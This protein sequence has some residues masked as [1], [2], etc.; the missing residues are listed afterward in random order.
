MIPRYDP[1]LGNLGLATWPKERLVALI[2]DEEGEFWTTPLKS[3]GE[4]L[5]L[6]FEAPRNG[7][8]Q[9]EIQGGDG[10]TI[11]RCDL[12]TGDRLKKEV[13]W[14]GETGIGVKPGESFTLHFKLKAAKLY[15]FELR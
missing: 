2:A 3:T 6:N 15:S 8:V 9:V 10:R 14:N 1:H 7:S 5:Y 11:E 12:L 13:T 4:R